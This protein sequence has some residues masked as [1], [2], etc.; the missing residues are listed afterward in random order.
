MHVDLLRPA[1]VREHDIDLLLRE[2]LYVSEEFRG[3]FFKFFETKIDNPTSLGVRHSV[4][5]YGGESALEVD[6]RCSS[7]R[8]V[9]I[10]IED[11]IDADFQSNQAERYRQAG[12]YYTENGE[13]G[14]FITA[15]IAPRS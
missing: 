2:E 12:E 4:D 1:D 7:G 10:L 3:F 5:R 13:C 8:L 14:G 9:R 15:L 11:K 6:V